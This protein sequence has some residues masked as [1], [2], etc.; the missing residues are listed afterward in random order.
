MDKINESGSDFAS[1]DELL[2]HFGFEEIEN[3]D[4]HEFDVEIRPKKIGVKSDESDKKSKTEPENNIIK[5]LKNWQK[6]NN[7]S[8]KV[9]NSRIYGN[10]IQFCENKKCIGFQTSLLKYYKN[11]SSTGKSGLNLHQSITLLREK[12][13]F[14]D[15]KYKKMRKRDKNRRQL[16]KIINPLLSKDTFNYKSAFE[17]LQILAYDPL[18]I[19]YEP[20][21]SYTND[22]KI[23]SIEKTVFNLAESFIG[24]YSTNYRVRDVLNDWLLCKKKMN[25]IG[26][27]IDEVNLWDSFVKKIIIKPLSKELSVSTSSDI[28]RYVRDLFVNSVI[29]ENIVIVFINET[30]KKF[31]VKKLGILT[32]N[33]LI[34]EWVNLAAESGASNAIANIVLEHAAYVLKNWKLG[35]DSARKLIQQ[36]PNVLGSSLDFIY[37]TISPI[38]TG[39]ADSGSLEFI[40][41]WLSILPEDSL[42]SIVCAYLRKR[43]EIFKYMNNKTS[44]SYKLINFYK[45][46]KSQI[47]HVIIFNKRVV[48]LLLQFLALLKGKNKI[49]STLNYEHDKTLPQP[50]DIIKSFA[51]DCNMLLSEVKPIQGYQAYSIGDVTIVIKLNV[52]HIHQ[53][54][55]LIPK[56][57]DEIRTIIKN[58]K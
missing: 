5:P 57:V 38:L 46:T 2:K 40:E 15:E 53:N 21:K 37:K 48:D 23:F 33:N 7:F 10:G 31:L 30:A 55:K 18:L 47:P 4:E 9:N 56:Y 52:F 13:D 44:D 11:V 25:S 54:N 24:E 45:E 6:C 27:L 43:L 14:I 17:C 1:G 3:D 19:R 39:T 20:E 8:Y 29:D 41:E 12:L 34:H 22:K 51:S 42:T 16:E 32:D 49:L 35:D 26:K 36:W 50:I 58:Q 28:C